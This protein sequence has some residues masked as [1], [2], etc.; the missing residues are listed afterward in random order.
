VLRSNQKGLG[1]V[2]A[3]VTTFGERKIKVCVSTADWSVCSHSHSAQVTAAGNSTAG[4]GH[5][6]MIPT[7]RFTQL[8]L[9][10]QSD[11]I[12][13]TPFR[14]RNIHYYSLI[15]FG[16]KQNSLQETI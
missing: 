15:V 3:K 9:P 6:W 12:L 14:K 2:K 4:Q 13:V 16:K 1:L 11:S 8:F 10:D 7:L 5:C